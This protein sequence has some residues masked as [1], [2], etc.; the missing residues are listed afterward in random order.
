MKDLPRELQ[1]A[2]GNTSAQ[3]WIMKFSLLNKD[4]LGMS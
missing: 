1:Q 4:I 2:H 3:G